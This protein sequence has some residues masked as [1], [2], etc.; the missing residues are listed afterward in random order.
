M[1][2]EQTGDM[3]GAV[4]DMGRLAGLGLAVVGLFTGSSWAVENC[5]QLS[6]I[7]PDQ[8]L[9][10]ARMTIA[11]S[12]DLVVRKAEQFLGQKMHLTSFSHP[13]VDHLQK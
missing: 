7:H 5:D 4:V 11:T 1:R 6:C 3:V 8:L 9:N 2:N 10:K 12:G 13:L